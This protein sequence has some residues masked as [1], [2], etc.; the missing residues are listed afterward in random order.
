ME[1]HN[2][3]KTAVYAVERGNHQ[4]KALAKMTEKENKS[5]C[6]KEN[7][8][9]SDLRKAQLKKMS[10]E[11]R[12]SFGTKEVTRIKAYKNSK[13]NTLMPLMPFRIP[14]NPLENPY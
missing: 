13:R 2:K 14:D 6:E 7:K 9:W 12:S 4:P 5:H 3:T 1:T 10:E 8:Q 11:Q